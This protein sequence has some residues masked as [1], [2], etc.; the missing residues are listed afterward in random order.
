M[1]TEN[2][3]DGMTSEERLAYL[4]ERGVVVESPEDRREKQSLSSAL[5]SLKVGDPGTRSFKYVKI[6]C[7]MDEPLTEETATVYSDPRGYGDQLPILL[8]PRFAAGVVNKDALQHALPKHLAGS[9]DEQPK[10]TPEKVSEMGGSTESFRL[11]D[12][13][14]MY[15]DEVGALKRLAP[16]LRA[17]QLAEQCGYGRGVTFCGDMYIGRVMGSPPQNTDFTFAEMDLSSPW[18]LSAAQENLARQQADNIQHGVSAEELATKGGSG[19]GYTWTQNET[20]IELECSLANNE[21]VQ[22]KAVVVKYSP[23]NLKVTIKQND[24]LEIDIKLFAPVIPDECSWHLS[25]GKLQIALEKATE[26]E[27]WPALTSS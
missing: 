13:V 1:K 2:E 17:A 25:D 22:K 8:A 10:L 26:G 5:R 15:L 19:D 7:N 18:I 27:T 21:A 23:K 6:P 12:S 14:N 11:S 16:N 3:D 20:E 4:R 9:S 24:T